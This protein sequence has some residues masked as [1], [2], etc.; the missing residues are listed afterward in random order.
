VVYHKENKDLKRISEVKNHYT[1]S[2]IPFEQKKVCMALF[3]TE[4]LSK[5]L[6]H[7]HADPDLFKL[8]RNAIIKLDHEKKG[9]ENIH[10]QL[11]VE[12][13]GAL[14]FR[15]FDSDE[16]SQQFPLVLSLEEQ[17]I[18]TA[19]LQDGM[20]FNAPVSNMQRRKLLDCM[21]HFFAH[22]IENFGQLNSVDI[23]KE[24][25]SA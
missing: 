23:L 2:S 18:L 19:L 6:R 10:L 5:C 11:L 14:G 24:V 16:I 3:I 22:H 1:F 15:T 4:I 17:H 7:D 13:A 25:M 9:F 12:L 20:E 21:L 8:I